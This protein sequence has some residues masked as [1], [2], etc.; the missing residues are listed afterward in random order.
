MKE[1]YKRYGEV[2]F[3][4]STYKVNIERFLLLVF[5]V[6]GGLGFGVPVLFAFVQHETIGIFKWVV[7]WFC[8][9]N[10]NIITKVIIMDKDI[11]LINVL[12]ST[13][14]HSSVLLCRFHV[15]KYIKKVVIQLSVP[16][17][18]KC[19]LMNLILKMVYAYSEADYHEAYDSMVNN[20]EFPESFKIYFFNNWH[21]CKEQW[22][23]AYRKNK[24]TLGNNTNNRIENFNRQLKKIIKPNMHLSE[25]IKRLNDTTLHISSDKGYK[26]YREIGVRTVATSGMPKEIGQSLTNFATDLVSSQFQKYSSKENVEMVLHIEVDILLT[27]DSCQYIISNDFTDCTCSFFMN[28]QLPCWHIFCAR[29]FRNMPLFDNELEM[30]LP[31]RWK[32]TE[33]L[34]DFVRSDHFSTLDKSNVDNKSQN[35]QLKNCKYE[36]ER[37]RTAHTETEALACYLA[38][39]GGADFEQKLSQVKHLLNLW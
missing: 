30:T 25:T 16:P 32:K 8:T 17:S 13:F 35:E 5:L 28:F 37:Y 3:V 11:G 29:D 33:V 9:Q 6:E 10:D 22:C 4:D 14:L 7:E 23:T 2:V 24:L 1:K 18:T 12:S 15:I 27:K 21:S 31:L 39:C 19:E 38:T 26:Q 36:E 20:H 34:K